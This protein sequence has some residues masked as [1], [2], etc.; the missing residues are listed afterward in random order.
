MVTGAEINLLGN[1]TA[2]I[3]EYGYAPKFPTGSLI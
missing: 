1:T 2:W 3:L